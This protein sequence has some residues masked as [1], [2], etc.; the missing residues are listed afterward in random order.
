M[1]RQS[2]EQVLV[3]MLLRYNEAQDPLGNTRV[4]SGAE[5]AIPW[6]P[7]CW[8]PEYRELERVLKLLR[9]AEPRLY[10]HLRHRLIDPEECVVRAHVERRRGQRR[11]VLP[12]QC[13]LVAGGTHV[14]DDAALVRVRR[15]PTW[16]DE[17]LVMEAVVR[18]SGMFR[19]SPALPAQ[20]SEAA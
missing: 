2:R 1:V 9:S 15:W 4:G 11:L 12:A 16:V 19:G 17:K 3:M 6:T 10:Q 8:T 13:E 7:L 18:L 5:D 20:F 14:S